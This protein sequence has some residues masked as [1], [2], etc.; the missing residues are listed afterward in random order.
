MTDDSTFRVFPNKLVTKRELASPRMLKLTLECGHVMHLGITGEKGNYR[1]LTQE[2]QEGISKVGISKVPCSTC[3]AAEKNRP[4][5]LPPT[6][7]TN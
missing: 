2:E 3:W 6:E 7:P 1:P 5:Q 4:P